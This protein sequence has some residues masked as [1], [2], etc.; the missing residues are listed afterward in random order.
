[1][2]EQ[3][4]FERTRN[5]IDILIEGL[6]FVFPYVCLCMWV[7]GIWMCAC[8]SRCSSLQACVEIRGWWHQDD[9]LNNFIHSP[10]FKIQNLTLNLKLMVLVWLGDHW[11]SETPD[12]LFY[13]PSTGIASVFI[14][15]KHFYFPMSAGGLNLGLHSKHGRHFTPR[16]PPDYLNPVFKEKKNGQTSSCKATWEC[17]S[18][19]NSACCCTSMVVMGYFD[20]V[21][22][23]RW[24][25]EA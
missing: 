15:T 8:E 19:V 22:W 4:D 25:D 2:K 14:K 6:C 7:Y 23:R 11:S 5:I 10:L 21:K 1:M 9:F 17:W 24:Q 13:L 16:A 20:S 18:F 12:H 3:I